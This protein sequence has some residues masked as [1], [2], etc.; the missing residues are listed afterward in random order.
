MPSTPTWIL[1]KTGVA[2]STVAPKDLVRVLMAGPAVTSAPIPVFS[3]AEWAIRRILYRLTRRLGRH[4]TTLYVDA[5]QP[6]TGTGVVSTP[7]HAAETQVGPKPAQFVARADGFPPSTLLRVA[8]E[9]AYDF[10]NPKLSLDLD[11]AAVGPAL[12]L[13][14]PTPVQV[15]AATGR[16]RLQGKSFAPA[17]PT[18]EVRLITPSTEWPLGAYL[19]GYLPA[20]AREQEVEVISAFVREFNEEYHEYLNDSAGLRVEVHP[21]VLELDAGQ[22]A[23]VALDLERGGTGRTMLAVAAINARDQLVSVSDLIGLTV[24]TSGIIYRDF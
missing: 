24:D 10:E 15:G 14:V 12:G 11:L 7:W 22:T 1:E 18:L 3:I 17:D 23:E 8:A 4:E 13:P 19:D 2:V 21:S 5:A 20:V 9:V 6:T 16:W